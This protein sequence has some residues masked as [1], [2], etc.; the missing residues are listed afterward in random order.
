M[1]LS[2]IMEFADA[3]KEAVS[4]FSEALEAK[5][6]GYVSSIS[7]RIDS[8]ESSTSRFV[9]AEHIAEAIRIYEEKEAAFFSALFDEKAASISNG[10]QV[11]SVAG[12]GATLLLEYTDGK[13]DEIEI[14][15]VAGPP[16]AK[17]MD[18]LNGADGKNGT[19]GKD[20]APGKDGMNGLDGANGQDGKDG[21]DG[22]DGKDGSDGK[23]GVD[24][25]NGENGKDGRDGVDGVGIKSVDTKPGEFVMVLTNGE[26]YRVELPKPDLPA[27]PREP[28]DV[29]DAMQDKEGNLI[30]VFSNG[31]TKDVGRVAGRDGSDGING[32]N[33]LD[34][35]RGEQGLPGL[36][37]RDGVDG[38][39]GRDGLDGLGFDDMS[40]SLQADNR[41]VS[42]L[43]QRG[44]TIKE[45]LL[46][47]PVMLFRGAYVSDAVYEAGDVVSFNGSTFHASREVIG[48]VPGS[49]DAWTQQTQAGRSI[50]GERGLPGKDG[51]N[52]L[53]GR[54]FTP[55]S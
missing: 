42:F 29:K 8:L 40:V 48:E 18:G 43:F 6:E 10:V 30:L 37:G 9:T 46:K 35:E 51:R 4:S 41:T 53:D 12:E 14:P 32:V 5:L 26:D 7:A 45:F 21:K 2:D 17:G 19:D 31:S 36:D 24:G 38:K 16:G 3:I 23:D 34:G 15:V 1:K 33:G 28:I 49:S 50:R 25:K 52:G 54:D 20:G 27:A 47:F 11:K 22:V 44:D 13:V 39:D 55:R